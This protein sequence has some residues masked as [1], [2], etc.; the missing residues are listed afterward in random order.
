MKAKRFKLSALSAESLRQK[1]MGAIMGGTSCTC[2]C[3]YADEPGGSPSGTNTYANYENGYQST[4][5][6]NEYGYSDE[7]GSGNTGYVKEYKEHMKSI[8]RIT[9]FLVIC[10]CNG[11][12]LNAQP[13]VAHCPIPNRSV[14]KMQVIDS[15]QVRV[16]YAFNADNIKDENTYIDKQCLDIGKTVKKYYSD[17]LFRED[18]LRMD[19]KRKHP[20]ARGIPRSFV[21]GG[22]KRDTWSEYQY[23]ELF[24]YKN[25]MEV[26]AAMPQ[27][28]ERYNA[29]YVEE[30]PL[31]KWKIDTRTQKIL[32]YVCQRA[33]TSWRGRVFE[34]WFAPSIPLKAG[35]WKFGGLPGLILK[36]RDMDGLYRFEA[37]QIAR[38]PSPIFKS[39][40]IG[41]Q[42][43][44]REKVWKQ[45]KTFNE[46]WWKAANYHKATIDSRGNMVQGAAVSILTPYE[47]LEKE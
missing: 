45:H 33:T 32:G 31:Q 6:C 37:V 10:L 8:W 40:Y 38:H 26:Y 35:P 21:K 34:A 14:G 3:Y 2:S 22:K 12:T 36:L 47:P 16:W 13:K 17:V 5:G 11:V 4:E 27:W 15:T 43:S 9:L 44:T 20:K 19:W 29:F 30:Y 39:D 18:T 1:E 23:S 28:L 7:Y 46:N 42:A 41:F 25:K 24:I